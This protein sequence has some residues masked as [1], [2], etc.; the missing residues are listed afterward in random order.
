M[1]HFHLWSVI[2]ANAFVGGALVSGNKL[3]G[4]EKTCISAVD[5]SD[6]LEKL[7]KFVGETMGP[8]LFCVCP[9]S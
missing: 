1:F 3:L 5:I 6:A 9:S 4:D 7:P 8:H 2:A